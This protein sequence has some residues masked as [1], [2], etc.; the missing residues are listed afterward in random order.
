MSS[1]FFSASFFISTFSAS[2]SSFESSLFCFR[3][4]VMLKRSFALLDC[5]SFFNTSTEEQSKLLG[6]LGGPKLIFFG[7]PM[8]NFVLGDKLFLGLWFLF[9]N[10]ALASAA[11]ASAGS[12]PSGLD[13][14]LASVFKSELF[15]DFKLSVSSVS[16]FSSGSVKSSPKQGSK[17]L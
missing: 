13:R 4:D 1:L 9:L 7:E 10:S 14:D 17:S 3:L 2:M 12:K 16:V 6:G 11:L 15:S 8:G 5:W